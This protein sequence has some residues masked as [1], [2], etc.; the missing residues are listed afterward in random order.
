MPPRGANR[1]RGRTARVRSSG[2][3]D[4]EAPKALSSGRPK[5]TVERE[6]L[7]AF[8]ESI[9]ICL[10]ADSGVGKT[11]QCGGVRNAIFL[12]TEKGV[13]SAQRTG[14]KADLWR[15]PTRTISKPR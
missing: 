3:S 12:S 5:V 9:N 14:S 8:N 1:G 13:V 6:S 11:V 10:Y 4:K 15:A 7:D 2:R